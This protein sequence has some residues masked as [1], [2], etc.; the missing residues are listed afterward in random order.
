MHDMLNDIITITIASS[1]DF[2]VLCVKQIKHSYLKTHTIQ[3]MFTFGIF[4]YI[5][6]NWYNVA[7]KRNSMHFNL[8]CHRF[9]YDSFFYFIHAGRHRKVIKPDEKFAFIWVQ[10]L[11]INLGTLEPEATVKILSLVLAC[12]VFSVVMVIVLAVHM[13]YFEEKDSTVRAVLQRKKR[14]ANINCSLVWQQES[15]SIM[16]LRGIILEQSKTCSFAA[17]R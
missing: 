3:T 15:S 12:A 4:S 5:I 2:D 14:I 8:R 13:L 7:R 1:A 16:L 11:A 17:N 6:H 9:N 10:S